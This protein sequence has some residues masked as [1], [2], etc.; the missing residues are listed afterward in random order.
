MTHPVAVLV[1]GDNISGK[2]AAAILGV[3]M[4]HGDPI[5]VR[6][7]LDAQR[8]S[9]WHGA[10]GYRLVHAGTGKNASD[11]LLAIDA[12]DLVHMKT[13]MRFIIASSD[14]DF[15]HLAV[16]LREFGARV[17]GVGEAKAPHMFR[18]SCS[19][20]VEL[21]AKPTVKLVPKPLTGVADLDLKIRAMIAEHSKQ[22]A[23]MC[24]AALAREMFVRHEI[25]ISTLPEKTWRSYL[26]A[27]PDLYDLDPR[28]PEAMVRFRP[29]GFAA[30][31]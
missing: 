27:R 18:A 8:A 12:M 28:G 7:Y 4:K 30:A 29:E 3:A 15:T 10:I 25:K 9:D 16:R 17:I 13:A 6:A 11:I 2:N 1:D 31:A 5:V 14:S 26:T 20:F 21:G 23:G 22:G 24:I 19:S